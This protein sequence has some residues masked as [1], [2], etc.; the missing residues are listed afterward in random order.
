MTE[1]AEDVLQRRVLVTYTHLAEMRDSWISRLIV[2]SA[3]G[4]LD[5]SIPYAGLILG[6]LSLTISEDVQQL[7]Q[8]GGV[9][10]FG[11]L[12]DSRDEALRILRNEARGGRPM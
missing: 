7:E 9:G 4:K 8:A 3:P 1:Q 10:A 11:F 6:A 12:V 5:L 2:L